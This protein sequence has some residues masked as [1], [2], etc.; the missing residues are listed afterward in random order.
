MA[1]LLLSEHE[2]KLLRACLAAAVSGACIP[3]WEFEALF[4]CSRG[5]ATRSLEAG[6]RRIESRQD[7]PSEAV[8]ERM[9]LLLSALLGASQ[10]GQMAGADASVHELTQLIERLSVPA[11]TPHKSGVALRVEA[12]DTAKAGGEGR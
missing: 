3:E 10:Q 4:G 1:R 6:V 11:E 9:V 5:R 12:T 2:L 7:R 8:C